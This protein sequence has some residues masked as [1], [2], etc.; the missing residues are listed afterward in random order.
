[1]KNVFYFIYKALFVLQ[2]FVF[3]SS[4]FF[5]PFSRCFR[6]WSKKNL[7]G[8]DV[9]NGLDKNLMTHFVWYLKEKI[10]YDIE[11]VSIDKSIK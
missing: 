3:S 4:P 7:K 11:T 10:R 2:I 5:L 6:G 1:M 8:S 9:I